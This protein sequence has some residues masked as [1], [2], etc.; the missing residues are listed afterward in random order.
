MAPIKRKNDMSQHE[1]VQEVEMADSPM[2]FTPVQAE[3]S[4]PSTIASR[5][6]ARPLTRSMSKIQFAGR[7]E[8]LPMSATSFKDRLNKS[9]KKSIPQLNLGKHVKLS[10]LEDSRDIKYDDG[11]QGGMSVDG[12][13]DGDDDANTTAQSQSLISPLAA[14]SLT[15]TS[16]DEH[17]VTPAS[18]NGSISNVRHPHRKRA[19][20]TIHV[21]PLRRSSRLMKPLTE[22]HKYAELPPELKLIIWEEAI[23]PR[24]VYINNRSSTVHQGPF[25]VQNRLPSW[26]L[27]DGKS[28]NIAKKNYEKR[29]ALITAT[30]AVNDNTRQDFNDRDIVI[31][32]PCHNGCRACHCA[33]NQYS[34]DDRFAVR[35]LAV[36]TDSPFLPHMSEPAWQ[37]V[38]R[39]WPN[40]ETL[41]L[42]RV[43]VKGVNKREKAMLRVSPN[44]QEVAFMARFQEWKKGPGANLKMT[45]IEFVVVV[46]KD[47]STKDPNNR[48]QTIQDRLTGLPEDVI[49][50]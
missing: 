14:D 28:V 13:G 6:F 8:A 16:I 7:L 27:G 15:N 22:F 46:D 39:S 48:Y 31:F 45:Q 33:R 50:G 12:D 20:K 17:E 47:D 1:D 18:S 5:A 26:F 35:F 25:E 24:L 34:D 36:Q 29:F 43:A 11:E 2:T 49:L 9:S 10:K 41:Y 19:R 44:A 38:S 21:G 30:G 42:M 37:S 23:E 40:V 4:T 3:A 32:E